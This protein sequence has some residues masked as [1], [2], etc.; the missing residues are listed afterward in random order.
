MDRSE[1]APLVRQV[2]V[3]A[4]ARE[5]CTLASIDYVDAFLVDIAQ[6]VT[7]E[8]WARAVLQDAPLAVRSRLVAGWSALGLKLGSGRSGRSL[9]GWE[10]RIDTPEFVLLGADSRIG[11][12]GELL[13]KRQRHAMLFCTFVQ[14]NNNIARAVWT[15]VEPTHVRTVRDILEH[16]GRRLASRPD[17]NQPTKSER[18]S[19]PNADV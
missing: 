14:H 17:D 9:L 7:A 18:V 6:H 15:A 11:M 3:P 12:P 1:K 8:Q 19:G 10:V 13:F 4:D 16:A 5:L 2:S